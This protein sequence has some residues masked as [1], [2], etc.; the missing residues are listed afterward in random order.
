MPSEMLWQ[1][2]NEVIISM[3]AILCG[4]HEPCPKSEGNMT[5]VVVIAAALLV[6]CHKGGPSETVA[7]DQKT[8]ENTINN[9]YASMKT[10]YSDGGVNTDSLLNAFYDPEAYYVTPWGTTETMDSTKNRLRA[11]IGHVSDYD[12]SIEDL[13]IKSYGS[14]ASTFFVLRQDYKVDGKERSEYLPTT[15]IL[16]KRG[17][18]WKIVLSHRSADPETWRQWFGPAR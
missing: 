15:A 12:F 8:I 17:D 18:G 13:S 2:R 14:G 1:R 6:S 16:E 3:K 4:R 5:Y 11:A 7:A 10:A 9:L